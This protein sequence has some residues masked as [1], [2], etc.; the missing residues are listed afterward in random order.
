MFI[1]IMLLIKE[2]CKTY[3]IDI[4]G[5]ILFYRLCT[6]GKISVY[7]IGYRDDRDHTFI[8]ASENLSADD[9][10]GDVEI[11][12][13]NSIA[14]TDLDPSE[15]F[16]V[17]EDLERTLDRV[18]ARLL[19][20]PLEETW[21]I[22]SV[23]GDS[24][25]Y[26]SIVS[27]MYRQKEGREFCTCLHCSWLSTIDTT[28]SDCNHE[29][30]IFGEGNFSYS[31]D[32]EIIIHIIQI[33]VNGLHYLSYYIPASYGRAFPPRRYWYMK[34]REELFG[35]DDNLSTVAAYSTEV[36]KEFIPETKLMKR[37]LH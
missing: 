15:Q 20:L 10:P 8:G 9:Q 22:F 27:D 21:D 17:E 13:R 1:E 3:D 18:V 26:E 14:D 25:N 34:D 19:T 11:F 33:G 24:A 6:V 12:I 36:S 16:I 31:D 4:K 32:V 37:A 2:F 7:M 28:C 5:E 30:H 29:E 23:L 35:D